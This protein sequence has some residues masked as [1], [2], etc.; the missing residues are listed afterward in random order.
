MFTGIVTEIGTVREAREEGDLRLV[1]ETTQDLSNVDLGA[2]IACSGVCLTVVGKGDDWFSVDVRS[3]T[4]DKTVAERW[5]SGARLNLER[6]LRLGDELGASWGAGSD[7]GCGSCGQSALCSNSL[8]CK[9]LCG[10][11]AMVV[12]SGR[13]SVAS[14]SARRAC[15]GSWRRSCPACSSR[16]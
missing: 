7:A 5:Q 11:G 13:C 10:A 9:V 4:R 1:V 2:S 3:A 14:S 15:C 12:L 8:R 16:S 6:A